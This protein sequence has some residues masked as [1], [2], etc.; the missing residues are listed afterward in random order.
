[1]IETRVGEDLKV[2]IQPSTDVG[3][4]FPVESL[5]RED[6]VFIV[7]PGRSGVTRK[8][9]D[10]KIRHEWGRTSDGD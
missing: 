5:V 7:L 3:T 1:M 4:V 10:L 2:R 8:D 6:G 9:G